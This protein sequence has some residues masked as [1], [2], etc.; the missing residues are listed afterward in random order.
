MDGWI[1]GLMIA[2]GVLLVLRLAVGPS[3]PKRRAA[4]LPSDIPEEPELW[5]AEALARHG[6]ETS[7]ADFAAQG[8]GDELRG[9]GYRGDIPDE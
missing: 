8:R 6:T 4:P 2:G 3:R 7:V 9:L 5:T 1:T